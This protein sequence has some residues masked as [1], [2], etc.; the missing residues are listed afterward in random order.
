LIGTVDEL[1][2]EVRAFVDQPNIVCLAYAHLSGRNEDRFASLLLAC[3]G[4]AAVAD[5]VYSDRLL[6]GSCHPLTD[7][8]SPTYNCSD[9]RNSVR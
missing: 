4:V 6:L 2:L 1:S 8:T 9:S 7:N 5:A 3:D